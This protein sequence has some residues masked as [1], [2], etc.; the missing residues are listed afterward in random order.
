MSNLLEKTHLMIDIETL[1]PTPNA[2]ILSIGAIF[3]NPFEQEDLE[4]IRTSCA[5]DE[6]RYFDSHISMSSCI[7]LKMDIAQSTID[8]WADQSDEA[9][10]KTFDNPKQVHIKTA[11]NQLAQFIKTWCGDKMPYVWG[12]GASFDIVILENAYRDLG[13]PIPWDFRGHMCYRTM[14]S[15]IKDIHPNKFNE[16]KNT[17]YDGLIDHCALDDAIYQVLQLQKMLATVY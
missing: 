9:R 11:L 2:A 4:G 5:Y 17:Q 16:I 10:E 3:F 14:K 1:A 7:S 8:W 6:R 15:I 13:L 12:N